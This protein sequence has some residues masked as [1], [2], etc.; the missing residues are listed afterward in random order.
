M[1]EGFGF[2]EGIINKVM[3]Q[4]VPVSL[5]YATTEKSP[6]DRKI[7]K[8]MTHKQREE[9]SQVTKKSNFTFGHSG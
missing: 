9:I 4:S 6:D 2:Y 8:F 7:G 3:R 5:R 1:K